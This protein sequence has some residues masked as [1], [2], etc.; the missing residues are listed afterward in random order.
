MTV[1]P[2]SPVIVKVPPPHVLPELQHCDKMS[3]APK[4]ISLRLT[5]VGSKR[6]SFSMPKMAD[7]ASNE[8]H[9]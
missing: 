6:K 7:P 5:K 9:D 4:A 2:F 1:I 8:S 3:L